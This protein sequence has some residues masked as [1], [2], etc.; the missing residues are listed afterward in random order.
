[1][2]HLGQ[3][4]SFCLRKMLSYDFVHCTIGFDDTPQSKSK[5]ATRWIIV[6]CEYYVMHWMS[7][8]ILR[9]FKNNWEM[10]FNDA[11]LLESERLKVFCIQRASY[12]LKVKNKT[13]SV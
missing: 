9:S 11:R 7:T 2:V 12:Y 10:Y 4:S 6:K 1:M 13:I 8:I 3:W 5:A